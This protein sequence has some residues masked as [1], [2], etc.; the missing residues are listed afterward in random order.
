M[1]RLLEHRYVSVLHGNRRDGIPWKK[2]EEK[3]IL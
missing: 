3:K 2:S 1:L